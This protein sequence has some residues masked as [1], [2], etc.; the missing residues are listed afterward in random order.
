MKHMFLTVMLF[1][2][3]NINSSSHELR[4]SNLIE[5]NETLKLYLN[6]EYNSLK[7]F[8]E[9]DELKLS[10]INF[11]PD[12]ST[13][14]NPQIAVRCKNPGNQRSFRTGKFLKF[15][16]IREGYDALIKDLEI[17]QTGKSWIVSKDADIRELIYARSP[18]FENDTER[19]IR[20][21][22]KGLGMP[23]ST[24]ISTINKH[25]FAKW[26]IRSEDVELFKLMYI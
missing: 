23:D 1:I 13:I 14:K 12:L 22:C 26:I 17:K 18:A 6:S 5:N 19:Y 9:S 2:S 10:R 20:N 15:E 16:T 3:W 21:V 24:K 25:D 4:I 8:I 11:F 7:E